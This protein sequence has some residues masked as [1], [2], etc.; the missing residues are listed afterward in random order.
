MKGRK[1]QWL[2]KK[3]SARCGYSLEGKANTRRR[4][5]RAE[6]LA[7]GVA[8]TRYVSGHKH[9][10]RLGASWQHIYYRGRIEHNPQLVAKTDSVLTPPLPGYMGKASASNSQTEATFL[11]SQSLKSPG[12]G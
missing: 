11:C 9:G 1:A 10:H 8:K 2:W 7:K 12:P 5:V 4:L 6:L 3:L